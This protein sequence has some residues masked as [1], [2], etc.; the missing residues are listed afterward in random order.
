MR[1]IVINLLMSL[2]MMEQFDMFTSLRNYIGRESEIVLLKCLIFVFFLNT[3]IVRD[4]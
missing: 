1:N 3:E 2:G 4:E